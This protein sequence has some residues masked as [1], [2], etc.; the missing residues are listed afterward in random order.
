MKN[1]ELPLL[2]GLLIRAFAPCN[3]KNEILLW[4]LSPG[5]SGTLQQRGKRQRSVQAEN[6]RGFA[7]LHRLCDSN[8]ND[9]ASLTIKA[10]L[11]LYFSTAN[12]FLF[13]FNAELI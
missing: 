6:G 3:L 7:V 8:K 2:S 11:H 4:A 13:I 10:L 12:C 5:W 9:L 1:R